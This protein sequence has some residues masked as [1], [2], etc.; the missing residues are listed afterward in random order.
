MISFMWNLKNKINKQGEEKQ[1]HRYEN[2]LM[3]ARWEWGWRMDEKVQIGSY[4][5]VMVM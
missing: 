2:I 1:T 3:V 5:I 4:R